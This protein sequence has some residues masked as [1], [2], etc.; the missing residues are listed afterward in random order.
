ML[1]GA[2]GLLLLAALALAEVWQVSE[3]YNGDMFSGT[4]TR[5]A[6]S[7]PGPIYF[8]A[9]MDGPYWQSYIVEIYE[10]RGFFTANRYNG[11]DG[12]VCG[13]Y[14]QYTSHSM[15]STAGMCVTAPGPSSF[16]AVK[17]S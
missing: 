16:T 17:S 5:T 1:H 8:N 13:Y 12:N 11:S 7:A 2:L 15:N 9:S 10:I 4:W 6:G 14:G 3:G